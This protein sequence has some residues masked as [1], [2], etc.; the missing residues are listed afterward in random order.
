ME[1]MI[2]S[3]LEAIDA[4]LNEI[5][6]HLVYLCHVEEEKMKR[7]PSTF[8]YVRDLGVG[9]EVTIPYEKLYA[10]TCAASYLEAEYERSFEILPNPST[11][12]VKIKRN[13]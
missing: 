7:E 6:K 3:F 10:V 8:S 2:T 4:R 11:E 13:I 9:D 1:S 12:T 5:N